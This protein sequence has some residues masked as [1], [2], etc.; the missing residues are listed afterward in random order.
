MYRSVHSDVLVYR[1]RQRRQACK[2]FHEQIILHFAKTKTPIEN[3]FRYSLCKSYSQLHL[4]AIIA[5]FE[6]Q[7]PVGF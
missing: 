4:E 3:K 6:V 7:K 5:L 1:Y 2:A